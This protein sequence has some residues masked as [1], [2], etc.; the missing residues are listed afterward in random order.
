MKY[1]FYKLKFGIYVRIVN[2]K[3][4][5]FVPFNNT[6]FKNDWWETLIIN[7]NKTWDQYNREKKNTNFEK[8]GS[9]WE[10]NNCLLDNNLCGL[11]CH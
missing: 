9:K 3:L 8:D 4:V 7:G 6:Q 1:M 10:I 11:P 5:L 2:N